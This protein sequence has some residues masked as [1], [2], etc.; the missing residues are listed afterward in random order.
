M[1]DITLYWAG[2]SDADANT[3][4]RIEADK[5]TSG[6]FA[7]VTT[8]NASTPYASYTTTLNEPD[9]LTA[10]AVS[11]TVD[12]S[13]NFADDDRVVIDKELILLD[14][15]ATATFATSLRGQGGTIP[16]A[17]ADGATVAKA[18]ETY[19]ES[20]VTFGSRKA[21]R[22]RVIRVETEGDS[23]AAEFLAVNPTMPPTNNLTRV[24]GAI[25]DI[26]GGTSDPASGVTVE[27]TI[28][29]SDNFHV[30]SGELIYKKSQSTTTDAD[31]YFE[32]L[33]PRNVARSGGDSFT[34]TIDPDGTGEYIKTITN[35]GDVDAINFLLLT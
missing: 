3:D 10:A 14:G 28:N 25:D 9:G 19:T 11:I 23:V 7:T 6:T 15:E 30:D 5:S 17:H 35:V 27:L 2:P 33:I 32:L 24:W 8:V 26:A 20:S 31:G 29:D 18:H 21:I 1:A 13:T 34:L 4:Y 16:V 22:Y 12:D